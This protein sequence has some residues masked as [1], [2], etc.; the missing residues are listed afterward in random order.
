MKPIIESRIGPIMNI[1]K[2]IT[3]CLAIQIV[4]IGCS[5][6]EQPSANVSESGIKVLETTIERQDEGEHIKDQSEIKILLPS[7][8]K[9][10][11]KIDRQN[12]IVSKAVDDSGVDLLKADAKAKQE[13]VGKWWHEPEII[14]GFG[15]HPFQDGVWVDITFSAVPSMDADQIELTG[16]LVLQYDT[17]E[18]KTDTLSNLPLKMDLETDGVETRIGN[19]LVYGTGGVE[20]EDI[21]YWS[22]NVVG[23]VEIV[24]VKV[25]GNDDTSKMLES[26]GG[27]GVS[28]TGF[29]L[30]QPIDLEMVTL[31]IVS[32]VLQN[33]EIPLD[34][35]VEIE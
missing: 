27:R 8:K 21:R 18:T 11:L 1:S 16:N 34:L 35:T 15:K 28:S 14:T 5:N 2:S 3:L 17:G 7:T 13:S 10:F 29:V 22:Y 25:L 23:D 32:K 20:T 12:S 6:N 31:E 4:L 26:T 24:R 33:K 19:I 30:L 9:D